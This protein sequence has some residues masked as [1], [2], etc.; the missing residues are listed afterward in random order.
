L[1]CTATAAPTTA[2]DS[3]LVIYTNC[4]LGLK[5]AATTS[6]SLTFLTAAPTSAATAALT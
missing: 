6:G 5:S 3:I 2:S 4:K 1:I